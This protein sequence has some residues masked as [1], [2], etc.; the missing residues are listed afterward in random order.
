MKKHQLKSGVFRSFLFCFSIVFSFFICTNSSI[1]AATNSIL[2]NSK[3]SVPTDGEKANSKYSFIAQVIPGKTKLVPY[4]NITFTKDS[5]ISDVT[6][7]KMSRI[8]FPTTNNEA[9][10]GKIGVIYQNVG[11]YNGKQIDL[12]IVITDW[13]QRKSESTGKVIGGN[14][15]SW[16][17][18]DIGLFSSCQATQTK[19]TY[20]D[21]STGLPVNV[22]GYM[23][24]NDID[25]L[26]GVGLSN[27]LFNKVDHIYVPSQDTKLSYLNNGKDDLIYT[28]DPTNTP[29]NDEDHMFTMMYSSSSMDLIFT[30]PM[31]Q[32]DGGGISS[33]T[34]PLTNETS[35][36]TDD[37][38]DVSKV[39]KTEVTGSGVGG[40]WF[41]YIAKK[42]L[43][44]ETLNPEKTVSDNDESE[45]TADMLDSLKEP[46]TYD[47]KHIVPDEFAEFYYGSYSMTDQIN[48]MLKIDSIKVTDE[49]DKDRSSNFISTIDNNLIKYVAT[50]S[51]LKDPNFYNHTYH[52]TITTHLDLSQD[53]NKYVENGM[54]TFDNKA[55]VNIDDDTNTS[56]TVNTKVKA[57]GSIDIS[58]QDLD[59][60]SKKL[61]GATFSLF[62]TKAN[63]TSGSNALKS[64]TT[65][66][67]G[68]GV[69]TDLSL[70]DATKGVYY[71]KETK[72]PA[73]YQL[74][75]T[76][77][78]VKAAEDSEG[79]KVNKV[80]DQQKVTI[81]ATGSNHNILVFFV[82]LLTIVSSVLVKLVPSKKCEK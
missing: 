65:D 78:E 1:N 66:K 51:A 17:D 21:H 71:L 4:G 24:F 46:V 19:W 30:N 67:D 52:W 56:N 82:L 44:T 28:N 25:W 76:V 54:V 10:K 75:S 73:G 39:A 8:G 50:S 72:A 36:K 61:A 3:V 37:S 32:T 47:I 45:V 22:T 40:S 29:D 63:A 68:N 2:N 9:Q 35:M 20:L 70:V 6:G 64:I 18:G 57:L 31:D 53:L 13:L 49:T 60:P 26:Q 33:K 77:Y 23:T 34:H 59:T 43:P 12:K 11:S 62:S 41:G 27:E 55:E 16:R 80:N 81:P 74:D 15:I 14:T 58:K 5:F 69:F 42:P 48:S 7:E 38:L 79:I